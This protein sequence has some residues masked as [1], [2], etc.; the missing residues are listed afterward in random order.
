MTQSLLIEASRTLPAAATALAAG[1]DFFM[2]ES[3]PLAAVAFL[4][5][6]GGSVLALVALAAAAVIRKRKL[7]MWIA[8]AEGVGLA[9]YVGALVIL[10]A[11]SR[12]R[13]LEAGD[14]KYFCELDCHIAY[15][16][17]SVRR[18]KTLGPADRPVAASGQFTIVTLKT[19]FDERSIGPARGNG[20]LTPNPRAVSIL[21]AAGRRYSPDAQAQRALAAMGAAATPLD[22]PLTPGQSYLTTLAFDL[23]AD[24]REPRLLV[25]DAESFTHVLIGHENSPFHKKISFAL[26]NNAMALREQR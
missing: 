4:G 24:A 14:Q 23:P 10:S 1:K 9:G 12:E 7:A 6:V 3:A 8:A 13:L 17:Q 22:R 26:S 18:A 25:T 15:S 11:G 2:P 19:W 16:L 5:A 20:P 21:D